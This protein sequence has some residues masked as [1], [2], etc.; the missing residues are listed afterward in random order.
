M[1]ETRDQWAD[2][3]SA[4]HGGWVSGLLADEDKLDRRTLWRLGSWGVAAVGAITVAVLASQ[5]QLHW[6]RDQSAASDILMRQAQQIQSVAKDA[7]AEARRL[8]HAIDTLNGDRDRLYSRV[9]SIEQGLDSVTGTIKR[10]TVD[11]VATNKMPEKASEQKTNEPKSSEIKTSEAKFSESK[12]SESKP[13]EIKSPA[14]KP[15]ETWSTESRSSGGASESRNADPKAAALPVL[16]GIPS[17]PLA[18]L[19]AVAAVPA[20]PAPQKPV[21]AA[22]AH[23]MPAA[24]PA[25]ALDA[26]PGAPE[27]TASVTPATMSPLPATPVTRTEFGVDIGGANSVEALRAIWRGMSKSHALSGLRPVIMVRERGTGLGMQL[28]LVAGPLNDAA[29]AAQICATLT[30]RNNRSCETTVFDGQRLT[31][32]ADPAPAPAR[33]APARIVPAHSAPAH[34]A[35]AAAETAPAARPARKRAAPKPVERTEL[36]PPKPVE[37]SQQ[38]PA[39]APAPPPKPS[40]SSFL[41]IR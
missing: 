4:E 25:S 35:P 33:V 32:R 21:D 37:E 9:T 40:L 24:D 18:A 12:S 38:A 20:V 5:S 30:E 29:E 10:Q 2:S 28:R 8:S 22:V 16:P 19:V 41:G 17:T 6:R 14:S 7:E 11:V 23:A 13:S 3:L 1:A 36:A 26:A 39:P 34:L 27:T 31:L 15:L